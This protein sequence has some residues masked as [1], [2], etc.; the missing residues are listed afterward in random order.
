[1]IRQGRAR[2][3][4]SKTGKP[5]GDNFG[6]LTILFLVFQTTVLRVCH[7]GSPRA[8]FRRIGLRLGVGSG[9]RGQRPI[10]FALGRPRKPRSDTTI[11]PRSLQRRAREPGGRTDAAARRREA[12]A[13]RH[14]ARSTSAGASRV[15]RHGTRRVRRSAPALLGASSPSRRPEVLDHVAGEPRRTGGNGRRDDRSPDESPGC[16]EGTRSPARNG[17]RDHRDDRRD[18]RSVASGEPRTCP[19]GSRMGCLTRLLQCLLHSFDYSMT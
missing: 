19:G 16:E 8:F 2:S 12:S 11:R 10:P 15:P 6:R 14:W 3:V 17:R 9:A 7:P 1:M 4:F 5:A 13:L 18:G